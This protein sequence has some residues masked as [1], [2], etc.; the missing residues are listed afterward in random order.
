MAKRPRSRDNTLWLHAQRLELI[1]AEALAR[2]EQIEAEV[3]DAPHRV[4]FHEAHAALAAIY[5]TT[6]DRAE[7]FAAYDARMAAGHAWN[8]HRARLRDAERWHRAILAELRYV[9]EA[10][11]GDT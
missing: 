4:A 2:Q 7:L 5:A 11:A 8:P 3:A 10:L 9:N 6:T 1:E